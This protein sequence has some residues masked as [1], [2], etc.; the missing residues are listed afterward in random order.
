MFSNQATLI[1]VRQS[2]VEYLEKTLGKMA[3]F[4]AAIL[5]LLLL[6]LFFFFF[7]I[8]DVL[9]LTLLPADDGRNIEIEVNY[10]NPALT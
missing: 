4:H 1:W 9:F 8:S 5:L 2:C 6:P 7:P 3:S 10:P